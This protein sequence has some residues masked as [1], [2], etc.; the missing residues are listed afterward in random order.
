MPNSDSYKRGLVYG[1][2]ILALILFLCFKPNSEPAS[3]TEQAPAK[4]T[5]PTTNSNQAG[6]TPKAA[7]PEDPR[8][9]RHP[10]GTVDYKPAFELSRR[11]HQTAASPESD[12]DLI[13][14]LL[15][16]YRFAYKENPVGVDNFE[17][18]EQLL[19]KNPKQVAFISP[20]SA[21][22]RGNEL[23]D[24]WDTPYRFHAVS[25]QQMEIRSAGPDQTFWTTDDLEHTGD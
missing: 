20:D 8:L 3:P 24:Q 19:G 16:H 23:V 13:Q 2:P 6:S 10:N 12:L 11:L 1:L 7:T 18:T 25:G 9:T 22:L 14:Q 17:I 21:A 15:G 4:P 5:E